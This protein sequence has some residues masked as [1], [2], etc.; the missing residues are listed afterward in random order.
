MRTFLNRNLL[1]AQKNYDGKPHSTENNNFDFKLH[2]DYRDVY[3][4]DLTSEFLFSLAAGF[5]P[6]L[7]RKI[8]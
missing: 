3:R 6:N 5:W 4:S 1:V 7:K 2:S 8:G